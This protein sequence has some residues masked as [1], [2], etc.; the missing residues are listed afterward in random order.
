[1]CWR[2]LPF[3]IGAAENL[4]RGLL[5]ADERDFCAA[6][7][8][9]RELHSERQ[10][11]MGQSCGYRGRPTV[12]LP[13]VPSDAVGSNI[14]TIPAFLCRPPARSVQT[15]HHKRKVP[16]S[17]TILMTS[18]TLWMDGAIPDAQY[19]PGVTFS[20]D[21]SLTFR[22]LGVVSDGYERCYEPYS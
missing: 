16:A 22:K 9:D 14:V 19:R 15:I 5:G 11:P 20:A 10:W 1:M 13:A 6:I 18:H 21:L 8:V 3:H 2:S 4:L 17:Q 12:E 7:C